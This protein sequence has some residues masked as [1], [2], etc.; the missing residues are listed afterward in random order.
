MKIYL[1]ARYSRREELCGY[2]AELEALGHTVTARWLN[3]S[4]QISDN[5]TPIGD[6]GESLVEFGQ[7]ER[8]AQLR[9]HFAEEDLADVI[10]ADLLVAFTEPPRSSA[11]RGGRYVEMGVAIGHG[12]PVVIVGPRENVFCWLPGIPAYATW[13]EAKAKLPLPIRME[14][15]PACP[16]VV[17]V[18]PDGRRLHACLSDGERV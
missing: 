2:R 12:I 15:C 18:E 3:G 9:Q 17:Y 5:G 10:R 8:A 7:T 16:N 14:A 4:H 11:S 1:A 13:N 6:D